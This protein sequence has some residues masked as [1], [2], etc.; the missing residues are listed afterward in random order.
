MKYI[1]RQ[2]ICKIIGHSRRPYHV[3]TD[4]FCRRCDAVVVQGPRTKDLDYTITTGATLRDAPEIINGKS[5]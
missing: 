5:E 1:L 2:I 3:R 4:A